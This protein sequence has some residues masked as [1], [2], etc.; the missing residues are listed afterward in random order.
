MEHTTRQHYEHAYRDALA[1]IEA[2]RSDDG[3]GA[4]K[5]SA[6]TACEECFLQ[7]LGQ[8]A[9]RLGDAAAA[10]AAADQALTDL[11]AGPGV[12]LLP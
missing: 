3:A 10:R 11:W 4:H 9:G 6:G 8:V 7:G 5:A 12:D 1:Y 2:V